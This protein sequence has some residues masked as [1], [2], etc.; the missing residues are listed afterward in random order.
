MYVEI[1]DSRIYF[2]ATSCRPYE[3][4]RITLVGLHGG[5]GIDGDQ[6]RYFLGPSAEWA[7]VV[8]P[9]QRGHGRSD[10]SSADF[11]TLAQWS[12][13]V[14]QFILK[15]GLTNV[16]LVGTSFGGFVTLDYLSRFPGTVL[17]GAIVG[18]SARRADGAEIV[19]RYGVVGGTE[20]ANVM[21]R[22][23]NYPSADAE[24]EWGRV[25]APLS[26][27]RAPDGVLTRIIDS[28]L[29]TPEVNAHF[30]S[31]FS[32]LDL[33]ENLRQVREPLLVLVGD[34]DPLTPPSV[35]AEVESY[36]GGDVFFHEVP[37]S[38]HQLIWDNP[39]AFQSMLRSFVARLAPGKHEVI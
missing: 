31:T 35:A 1:N 29:H 36:S 28:Q 9:D 19:E 13:D 3:H 11:W 38:S 10:R 39:D 32:D 4:D 37:G 26:R 15:L 23:L 21:Q 16:V 34:A 6:L 24:A 14:E 2:T 17:G 22:L 5:P 7:D 30:M 12:M 25:C 18:S 8:V 33:R 27:L 20:A